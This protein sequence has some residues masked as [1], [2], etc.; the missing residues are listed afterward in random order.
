MGCNIKQ[1]CKRLLQLPLD[2]CYP[3]LCL[4]CQDLLAH[5]KVL[6]CPICLEQM[7]LIDIKGRC[8]T[9]FSE[10]YQGK[11]ERC[12]KRKVVVQR[13][14]ATCEMF[15][16]AKAVFN[17]IQA[18]RRDCIPAA[19]SLMAYQWLALKL[20]LP[21]LLIPVPSSFWEK[22]KVGF[23]SQLMLAI[24]L[25]KIFSVPVKS[26]LQK[27][28]DR[29]QFLTKGEFHSRI[30]LSKRK[31]EMLCDQKVLIVASLLNDDQFRCIGIELKPHFPAQIDALAFATLD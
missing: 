5:R 8:R 21:D 29:E 18:G 12:I 4:Y 14:I 7:S 10:I 27:K 6:F 22:Q 26:I 28:L 1:I 24:E 2:L 9:C 17:G 16:P 30:Q 11:C 20:P 25:S 13:Q 3:P 23:D 15:G 19:A 31:K